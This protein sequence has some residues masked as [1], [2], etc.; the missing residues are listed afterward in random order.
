MRNRKQINNNTELFRSAKKAVD[1]KKIITHLTF[2]KN[3]IAK[4]KKF[5]LNYMVQ[6]DLDQMF[7]GGDEDIFY[8]VRRYPDGIKVFRRYDY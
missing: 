3:A 7:I 4:E 2:A 8:E 1:S 5:L 6:R